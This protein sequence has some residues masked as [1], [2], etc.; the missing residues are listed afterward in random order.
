[1]VA[2][3]LFSALR[4]LNAELHFP[5]WWGNV[6]LVLLIP[7]VIWAIRYTIREWNRVPEKQVSAKE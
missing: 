6:W 3:A 5:D 7:L 4:T 1:M 2:F